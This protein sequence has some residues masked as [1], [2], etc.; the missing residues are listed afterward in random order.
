M[1]EDSEIYRDVVEKLKRMPAPPAS[2]VVAVKG[3]VVR[4][5][6]A[7]EKLALKQLV[8][9]AVKKIPGVRVV[10]DE[11][12]VAAAGEEEY[13]DVELA[14]AVERTLRWNVLVPNDKILVAVEK[15][16]VTLTGE[17]DFPYQ[18]RAAEEAVSAL[19]HVRSVIN[20]IALKPAESPRDLAEKIQK[21]F[22]AHPLLDGREIQIEASD[23][24]IVLRGRVRSWAERSE[25][26]GIAGSVPG[27]KEVDNCLEVG[28]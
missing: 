22:A 16:T 20:R 12:K 13:C 23:G 19:R 25:A 3:G 17:V 9:E 15:G 24:K 1:R 18:R 21:Q 6:G 5:E 26:G 14:D 10:I 8:E 2:V 4:L 28:D 27:V 7:I 11:L